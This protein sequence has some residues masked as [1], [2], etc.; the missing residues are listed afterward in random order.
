M[1]LAEEHQPSGPPSA[2]YVVALTATAVAIGRPLR[3]SPRATES[4]N[5]W[6]LIAICITA[7]IAERASVRV[8]DAL[9]LSI[10]PVPTLFAAVLFGPLAGGSSALPQNSVTQRCSTVSEPAV[11]PH[12]KWLTYTSTRFLAGAAWV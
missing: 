6:V 12:L 11:Q 3:W 5:V 8:S 1:E 7:A 2:G 10:S 4:G 9:E